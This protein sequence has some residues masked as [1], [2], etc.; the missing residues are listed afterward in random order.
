MIAGPPPAP[1][2][3]RTGYSFGTGPVFLASFSTILGAILFLRFGYAVGNTGMLGAFAIIVLGHM[4]TIP[5]A[6]AIS[7]IAT[8]RRVEGGGEYFIIS[9]SFGRT[10]GGVIGIS[11]FISQAISV[12]FYLAAFAEA[13]SFTEPWF[14]QAAGW[15][16]PR[17]ISI[18]AAAI[19]T[20]LIITRGAALGVSALLVITVV[21]SIA[22]LVFFLGGSP[23]GVEIERPLLL[24]TGPGT[25]AFMVV[26]AICFPAFTGMTAGV[27]LSGDLANPR[28]SIPAG[29]LSATLVAAIV[30]VGVVV[31][32]AT[33]ATPEMLMTDQLV[34]ARVAIWGPIVLI[35]LACATFSSALGSI[36]VAP[37]TLQALGGDDFVPWSKVNEFVRAGIGA[38]NEP[39]NATLL[40]MVIAG[41]MLLLGSMDTIARIVSMFFMVT[42]GSLCTISFLEHFAARPAYRPSFKSKWY[43]SLIGSVMCLL[44]M[45]LM[46]PLFATAAI[47]FMVLLYFTL[48]RSRELAGA[49][50]DSGIAAIFQGAMAQATRFLQIKLQSTHATD[51]RPSI[52]MISGRTFDRSPPL[53]FLVWLCKR[54]GFG[55]YV[56]FVPGLLDRETYEAG[57]RVLDQL[58]REPLIQ[59]SGIYM[60]TMISPSLRSALAQ[61][62]QVPGVSGV[63]N[64]T[65]LFEFSEHDPPEVLEEVML[66]CDLAAATGINRLV[67]RHGDYFFGGKRK[68]HVWLTWHDYRNASLLILIAYILLAHPDWERAEITI[69]AAYPETE[70]AER[71]RQLLKMIG[72]GRIP[73]SPKNVDIIPT[74]DQ[75]NFQELVMERSANADIVLLGFTSQRLRE[76]GN[77]VFGRHA[78][79]RDVLFVNAEEEIFIE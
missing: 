24:A 36:L 66:G 67:L 18:P 56:H 5:T 14:L 64:N 22:I 6:L 37:R 72:E 46:D 8:N 4:V 43:V 77:E 44:L 75:S 10:I 74:T 21:Q 47:L 65:I 32:L 71:T 54:Y 35:G 63:R 13:F 48:T 41:T 57:E 30:Y 76:L 55:T 29:I 15:Y 52:I 79:L 16:D 25:D 70:V 34:M 9:R 59:H 73:I 2:A 17:I 78:G 38:A 26:F 58:I 19:L 40:T 3:A 31:K 61:T 28:K 50:L 23:S 53:H 20:W 62:L 12:A 27:G 45:F 42:Y 60:D 68:I 7:E 49:E 39:R 51:W 69:F 11:L 33:S 1:G